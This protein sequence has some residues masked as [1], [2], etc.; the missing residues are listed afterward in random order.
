MRGMDQGKEIER[1]RGMEGG[2]GR[3]RGGKGEREREGGGER[4][5]TRAIIQKGG[6]VTQKEKRKLIRLRCRPHFL[7]LFNFIPFLIL[8]S[9]PFFH[10]SSPFV[11]LCF[12]RSE[13]YNSERVSIARGSALRSLVLSVQYLHGS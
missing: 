1:E 6:K 5:R 11:C 3:G 8:D 10:P 4:V 12:S 2:R 13:P 9:L 7:P